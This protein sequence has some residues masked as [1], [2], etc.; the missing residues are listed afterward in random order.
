MKR[1]KKPVVKVVKAEAV[2]AVDSFCSKG[3]S[4][5]RRVVQK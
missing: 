3:R 5:K 4:V 1:P 2:L